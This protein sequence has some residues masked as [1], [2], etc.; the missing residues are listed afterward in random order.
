MKIPNKRNKIKRLS[1]PYSYIWHINI[2]KCAYW[3]VTFS[4]V[5]LNTNTILVFDIFSD[6]GQCFQPIQTK[7]HENQKSGYVG[8]KHGMFSKYFKPL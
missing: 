6:I 3:L 8:L 4:H 7:G 2:L 1:I 5:L